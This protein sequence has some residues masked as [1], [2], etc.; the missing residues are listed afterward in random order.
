[1]R[2]LRPTTRR[3]SLTLA[4]ISLLL[5]ASTSVFAADPPAWFPLIVRGGEGVTAT[6]ESGTLTVRFSIARV[7]AA[8]PTK[9]WR[10]PLG[11][12]AWVNRPLN[13]A[14]PFVLKQWVNQQAQQPS[15]RCCA[16]SLVHWLAD[17]NAYLESGSV[18]T[19][20][21]VCQNNSNAVKVGPP[22]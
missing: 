9:Y 11:S 22:L 2:S 12:A 1:M 20:D 4:V 3:F 13:D 8:G 5:F 7:A 16:T 6:Y 14:E 18:N 15:L 10:V 21:D 17:R 19:S